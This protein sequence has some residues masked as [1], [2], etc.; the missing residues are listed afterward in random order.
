MEYVFALSG[1]YVVVCEKK[2]KNVNHKKKKY[3]KEYIRK[4][5]KVNMTFKPHVLLTNPY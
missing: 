5:L 2:I 1:C 3:K 4:V